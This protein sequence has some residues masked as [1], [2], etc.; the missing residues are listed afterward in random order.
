MIKKDRA[1]EQFEL[2]SRSKGNLSNKSILNLNKN[3]KSSHIILNIDNLIIIFISIILA[4]IFSFSL[5]VEKGKRI[6]IN[7]IAKRSEKEI[8]QQTAKTTA[9]KQHIKKEEKKGKI[10]TDVKEKVSKYTVQVATYKKGSYVKKEA[11]RLE[12]EGYKI[13]VVPKGK[14]I[15]LCVGSFNDKNQAKL[16]LKKLRKKYQDCFIRRL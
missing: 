9:V 14:F 16:S 2:F 13:I 12:K 6:N 7:K 1:P 10:S 15:E 11:Q 3:S 8:I 4:I 5:G